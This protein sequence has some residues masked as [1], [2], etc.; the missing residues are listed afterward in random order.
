MNEKIDV[1]L[2]P[3]PVGYNPIAAIRGAMFHEICVPFNSHIGS[4]AP[5]WCYVT[6]LNMIQIKSCGDISCLYLPQEDKT[7][8]EPDILDVINR[9]NAQEELVKLTLVRP[10]FDEIIGM[11]TE[12]NFLISEK[13]KELN[14][15]NQKI[16]KVKP[17]KKKKELQIQ[18]DKIEYYLGFLL[19]DDTMSFLTAWALGVEITDIKKMSRDI[20]L[21]AA[22]M[23][24]NGKDN[25]TD[26]I[27]GVFTDFQK[28][29]INKHAWFIYKQFAD[30]K[31][32]EK[33]L[34][35][36]KY[37]WIGRKKT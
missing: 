17:A 4:N 19:P 29:D 20:L 12:T 36:S 1:K 8:K 32:R 21:D 18:A 3:P 26:H 25:P 23:A 28:E 11:V 10:S 24:V 16:K 33:N 2:N 30:D 14:E 22:I 5:I 34:K 37:K 35:D 7:E 27:T 9:K 6:C 13:Q 31:K 15:I